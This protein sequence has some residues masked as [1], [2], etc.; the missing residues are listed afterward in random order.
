VESEFF[1]LA[2]AFLVDSG[3]LLASLAAVV[4]VGGFVFKPVRGLWRWCRGTVPPPPVP[5]PTSHVGGVSAADD[6]TQAVVTGEAG[7]IS[8]DVTTVTG[9]SAPTTGRDQYNYGHPTQDVVALGRSLGVTEGAVNA[10]LR[11][12]GETEVPAERIPQTLETM[13]E[14]FHALQAELEILRTNTPEVAEPEVAAAEAAIIA[15]DFD[16]AERLL[17]QI[18]EA[19]DRA[20]AETWAMRGQARMTT[21]RY[22]EAAEAYFEAAK[23][24]PADDAEEWRKHT[25]AGGLA[26][27][28]LG[29]EFGDNAAL[30]EAADVFRQIAARFPRAVAV[31]HWADTQNLIGVASQELGS[32]ESGTA[33][34]E[35][36]VVAFRAALREWTRERAP[37]N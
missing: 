31:D 5:V 28:Q 34:L 32:R 30:A 20:A 7:D 25:R 29:L 8:R 17:A 35:E 14:R 21:L 19:H 15:G 10:F 9:G 4:G 1:V 16:E 24:V 13:A 22:R 26:L 27:R 6:A 23:R 3:V 18:G 12:I 11:R 2:E 36:A 37:V 33:R